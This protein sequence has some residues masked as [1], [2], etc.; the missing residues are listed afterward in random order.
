MSESK[1]SEKIIRVNNLV[2][3]AENVEINDANNVKITGKEIE[4]PDNRRRDPWGF[5]W[6]RR[7]EESRREQERER[8]NFDLD[9][10]EN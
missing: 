9:S 4:T 7:P 10:Q 1:K 8:E 2:I 3:H 5:F 6:G